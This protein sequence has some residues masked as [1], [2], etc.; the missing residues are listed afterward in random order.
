MEAAA[1][2]A[3]NIGSHALTALATLATSTGKCNVFGKRI[4][5]AGIDE[6]WI[7]ITHGMEEALT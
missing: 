5:M 2:A 6:S 4:P 7:V 1:R 3:G